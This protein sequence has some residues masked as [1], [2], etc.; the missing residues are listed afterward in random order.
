MTAHGVS[1]NSYYKYLIKAY[2]KK[3][4]RKKIIAKSVRVH[5]TT[6][7]DKYTVAKSVEIESVKGAEL[8]TASGNSITMKKG[9]PASIVSK[10]VMEE[11]GKT[12]EEHHRSKSK[13]VTW[14]SNDPAVAKVSKS[15][16]V[17]AVGPGECMIYGTAQN[18]RFVP[19]KISVK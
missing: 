11:S 7:S 16:K 1:N 2:K 6:T 13:K 19:V 12:V 14:L 15:G 18:G 9:K 5:A 8:T 3:G 4:N 10:E 17:K